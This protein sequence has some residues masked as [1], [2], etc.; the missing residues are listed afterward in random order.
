M[1]KCLIV[2]DFQNDFVDGALGFLQAKDI[3]PFILSKLEK[4]HKDKSDII[5]TLDTHYSNYLNTQEGKR[6]PIVHCIDKTKG[7]EIY[8][9]V[10]DYFKYA[11]KVFKK[12]TFGSL[13]LGNY[14]KTKEYDEI[15]LVGLVTNMCVVS[16]AIIAKAALP[17]ARI[18]VDSNACRSF[19]DELHFKT[20]DVLAGMQINV[21]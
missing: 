7:Q 12:N 17:E 19:N 11:V 3:E 15:E 5:F 14:L 13:D 18:V 1:N 8:G 9:K 4:Y 2:V 21:I 20:L 6:L 10:N 16:N